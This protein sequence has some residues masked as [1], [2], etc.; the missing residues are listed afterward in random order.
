MAAPDLS[1]F[2]DFDLLQNLLVEVS[3]DTQ[4][5]SPQTLSFPFCVLFLGRPWG[6]L[7]VAAPSPDDAILTW[8]RLCS[9]QTSH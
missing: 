6:T 7:T 5:T 2:P 1:V 4:D 8:I 9:G 3:S